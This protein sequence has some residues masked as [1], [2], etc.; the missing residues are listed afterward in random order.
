MIVG[1]PAGY[2]LALTTRPYYRATYALVY[3]E[4]RKLD[5]ANALDLATLPP[6]AR[7]ALRIG[8]FTPGPAAE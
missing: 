1:V 2:D 7:D 5:I 6:A 8:V 4:G 3:V